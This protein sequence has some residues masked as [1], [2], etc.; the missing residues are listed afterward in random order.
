[1]TNEILI[2]HFICQF[3]LN[4]MD[5]H[6]VKNSWIFKQRTKQAVKTFYDCLELQMDVY[7]RGDEK[8]QLGEF[9]KEILHNTNQGVLAI[10]EYFNLMFALPHLSTEKLEEF[11]IEFNELMDK[12]ELNKKVI[13]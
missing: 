10:G 7:L 8:R 13:E 5:E 1:M 9:N 4:Y 2:I 6:N 3:L 11:Q 12:Y